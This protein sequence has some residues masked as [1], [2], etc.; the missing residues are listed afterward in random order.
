MKVNV[1]MNIT[2]NRLPELV[3]RVEDKAAAVVAQA[4]WET[5]LEVVRNCPVD[6]GYLANSIRA[7][8]HGAS[9][10]V[11]S[12]AEYWAYVEYGTCKMAAIPYVTPAVELVAPKFIEMMNRLIESVA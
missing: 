2:F 5:A 12:S 1:T 6:T 7:K 10:V 11:I 3:A 4:T 9:G 8:T